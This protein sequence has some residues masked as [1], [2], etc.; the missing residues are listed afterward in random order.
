M[1]GIWM[2]NLGD[3]YNLYLKT[4]VLN[5]TDVWTKFWETCIKYYDLDPS[6]Y[7]SA[8]ALSWDAMLKMT[9]VRIEL[10][11]EMAMHD[12]IE[13]A[14]RRGIAMAMHRYFKAN[15]PSIGKAFDPSQPTT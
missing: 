5:L 14:K 11:T 6:H 1:E 9:G 2:K 4:D 10:F 13:K 15:N 12:F 7:I 3:Y 8:P